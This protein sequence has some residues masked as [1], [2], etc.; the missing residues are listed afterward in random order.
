MTDILSTD[1]YLQRLVGAFR[2][3]GEKVLAFYDHRVGGHLP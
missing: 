3:G 1:D 2:P